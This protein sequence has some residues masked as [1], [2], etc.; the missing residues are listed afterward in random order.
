MRQANSLKPVPWDPHQRSGDT[1]E[2]KR[3]AERRYTAARTLAI[4]WWGGLEQV[5]LQAGID[6]PLR[7]MRPSYHAAMWRLGIDDIRKV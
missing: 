4:R 6:E 2:R 3:I 5:V 1:A 7:R